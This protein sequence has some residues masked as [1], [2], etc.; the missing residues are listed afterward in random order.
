MG[1]QI[2][3]ASVILFI[4]GISFAAGKHSSRIDSLEKWRDEFMKSWKEELKNIQDNLHGEL[5]Q[6]K[7]LIINASHAK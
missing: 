6:V 4:V 5:R 2:F 1:S 7:D 3:Q